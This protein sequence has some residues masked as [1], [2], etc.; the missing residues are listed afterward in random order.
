M[1]STASIFRSSFFFF[2]FLRIR[3]GDYHL[4]QIGILKLCD[5]WNEYLSS[6]GSLLTGGG[7]KVR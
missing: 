2:F 6:S 3:V 7:M 1:P 4:I 5:A